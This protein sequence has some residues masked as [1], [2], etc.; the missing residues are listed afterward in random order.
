VRLK[1]GQQAPAF[2]AQDLSGRPVALADYRGKTLLLSFYRMA[3]CPLCN[4]RTF[5]LINRY[6]TYQ[7]RGVH[8][9]AFFESSPAY[10]HRYLIR[11]RAPFPLVVDPTRTTYGLYGLE[12]S[13]FGAAYAR[14][15]R[16]AVYREA[17][18]RHLGTVFL[19]Y[20]LR[21]EGH[22]ARLPA[23][24][25]IGPDSRVRAAYYGRDAGDFM[26]FSELDRYLLGAYGTPS[27]G[28]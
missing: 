19:D 1:V 5:L 3:A 16:G 18:R 13:W 21:R 10:A 27:A 7:R 25:V 26:L 6:P 24:F 4:V 14:L 17:S 11:L 2:V 20:L 12:T 28:A 15:F 23:E 9:V 22:F 8:M